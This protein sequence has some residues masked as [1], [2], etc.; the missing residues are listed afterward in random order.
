MFWCMELAPKVCQH[1]SV[2]PYI[3]FLI[4]V[5]IGS[6]FCLP[7]LGTE[8]LHVPARYIRDFL[9]SM[10]AHQETIVLLDVL[11][12]LMLS[13]GTLKYLETKLHPLMTFIKV[14]L[15]Y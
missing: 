12:L 5:D 4:Q 11:Q 1:L 10:P 3:M 7:L 13:V 2:T 6:K 9:C 15:S 14:L 8:S